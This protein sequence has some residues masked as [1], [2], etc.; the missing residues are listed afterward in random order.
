MGS[1]TLSGTADAA[2]GESTRG[3]EQQEDVRK[4]R[5]RGAELEDRL[6]VARSDLASALERREFMQE[7]AEQVRFRWLFL[8]R[9]RAI[10]GDMYFDPPTIGLSC[11]CTVRGVCKWA[12]TN[13]V[14][15]Q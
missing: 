3:C 1:G 10:G 9:R 12:P 8:F 6:A 14:R 5:A 7:E 15:Q 11:M 13:K 2:A 4:L